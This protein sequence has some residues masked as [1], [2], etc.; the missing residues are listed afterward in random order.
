[1]TRIALYQVDVFAER[2]FAGNP[3]AVCPLERWLPDAVMQSIGAENNL[4]E[5]AFFV[6]DET[7][8]A[9]FLLRW[10]TPTLEIELCGHATLASGHVLL[11]EL[12]FAGDTVRFRTLK[13][14]VLAVSRR[15]GALWL[16]LPSRL[17]QPVATIPEALLAGI[18]ARPRELLATGNKYFAVFDD[19]RQVAALQ[20]DF[21]PLKSLT[22]MGV[23]VT[24]PGRGADE[25]FVSRFFAPAMGVDEDPATGSAHCL[26]VPFWAARLGRREFAAAQLSPRGA[27][28]NCRLEGDRVFMSGPVVPYLKGEI[29]LR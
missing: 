5:T 8:A 28:M 29:T 4:A 21:A 10:F 6:R 23:V 11:E 14:G 26:L 1:M 13:A 24:A 22:G 17:P 25:H 7:S 12:G 3:A 2:L 20:P 19:A 9:N 18:G 27:K 15:D 16:D